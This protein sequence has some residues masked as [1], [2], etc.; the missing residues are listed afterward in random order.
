MAMNKKV[1]V[2]MSGGVDSSVAAYLLKQV[3]YNV[4]GVTLQMQPDSG[5]VIEDARLAAESL[6]IPHYTVD[7][8][9][10][11]KERVIDRFIS[12]Y[13]SARTPNPCIVCNRHVKWALLMNKAQELG[14]DY[15]ATGHYARVSRNA[16]GRFTLQRSGAGKKD[17]TYALYN[18]TQAQL[19]KTLMPLGNI[20]KHEVR[21]IAAEIGLAIADKPDSQDIC[22]IPDGDY[23]RFV[24]EHSNEELLPGNFI[25]PA[26]NIIGTHQGITGYTIGQRR[27]LKSG[28]GRRIYV[29]D[30]DPVTRNITLSDNS[31]LF[32]D[33]LT[34]SDINFVHIGGF[35][36][37]IRAEGK[38]RYAAT[39]AACS[40][41]Y[42]NGLL[43][44]KFDEPQRAATPGQAAVFYRDGYALFGGTI[45]R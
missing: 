28:F 1:V 32:S 25:D 13:V 16:E 27:G 23:G 22:F 31:A 42:E 44:V 29:T 34:V 20:E 3:G 12:E 14:A 30:I 7:A 36:G 26:G 8:E 43:R 17:Q 4:V 33:R 19:A 37:E 15:I 6:S 2:A 41:S 5:S 18:L 38:I 24:R 39:P 10:V 9:S 21:R 11:F 40:V 45:V 35:T